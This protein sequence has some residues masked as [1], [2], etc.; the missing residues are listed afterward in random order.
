MMANF[1]TSFP[2][3]S[4]YHHGAE[5][6]VLII[7][8]ILNV[9]LFVHRGVL[10][11]LV[12][13]HFPAPDRN[14]I[15]RF[16]G[17]DPKK[18]KQEAQ[19]GDAEASSSSGKRKSGEYIDVHQAVFRLIAIILMYFVIYAFVVRQAAVKSRKRHKESSDS[20]SERSEDSDFKVSSSSSSEEPSTAG[21]DSESSEFSGTDSDG[22]FFL[23][24]C[25]ESRR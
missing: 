14:R 25:L 2:L 20:D 18:A 23:F 1:Q 16:L 15:H 4:L 9:L 5:Y 19:N 12:E 13:K 10:Q 6:C 22:N 8:L 11:S 21:S 3:Q 7:N 17:I 24:F